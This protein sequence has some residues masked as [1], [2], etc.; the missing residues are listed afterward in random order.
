MLKAIK[1]KTFEL[2]VRDLWLEIPCHTLIKTENI[3]HPF[4]ARVDRS[5]LGIKAVVRVVE[6]EKGCIIDK[7][8]SSRIF[9]N[10]TH[11]SK[12]ERLKEILKPCPFELCVHWGPMKSVRV[13][14]QLLFMKGRTPNSNWTLQR[15]PQEEFQSLLVEK[16]FTIS[17]W[18]KILNEISTLSFERGLSF[19]YKSELGL[20]LED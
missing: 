19:R 11:P 17:K 2:I 4:Y 12:N 1:Q 5:G 9:S 8:G 16:D 15:K 14:N 3:T 7:V 13:N 18:N 6:D 10:P 20:F